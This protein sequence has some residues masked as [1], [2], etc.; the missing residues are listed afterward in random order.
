MLRRLVNAITWLLVAGSVA[1]IMGGL[2]GRPILLASVPTGSMVPVFNPG[3]IIAVSPYL[4]GDLRSG[5]IVVFRTERDRTWIVHRIIGGDRETGFTTQGDANPLPDPNTVYPKHVVGVVPQV[6]EA[7]LRVP[8]LGLLSL[9]RGPLSNPLVTGLA[10]IIGLYLM[11]SDARAG[12]DLFRRG[13]RSGRIPRPGP[14]P[15]VVMAL[16]VGLTLSVFLISLMTMWSL[17]ST[18][19]GAF[20]VVASRDSTFTVK[21]QLALGETREQVITLKN[22]SL[23]P[24]IVGM[25]ANTPGLSFAPSWTVLWPNSQ[26]DV[27]VRITGFELGSHQFHMRQSVFLPLLPPAL[28]EGL[29]A[30]NWYLPLYLVALLPTMVVLLLAFSD[31]RVWLELHAVSLRLQNRLWG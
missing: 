31:T 16:Y 7:A 11:A 2:L 23:I 12:L 26:L 15:R 5:Q 28:L 25:D 19:E 21:D 29:S 30:V 17:S 8:R 20:R 6:G 10:L 14:K 1:I 22:P 3:D 4:G 13:A 18:R 27:T 24:L 9:E